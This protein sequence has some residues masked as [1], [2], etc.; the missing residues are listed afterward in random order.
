[1]GLSLGAVAVVLLGLVGTAASSLR[2]TTRRIEAGYTTTK[3]TYDTGT[4][5]TS[6]TASSSP[7]TTRRSGSTPTSG[8]PPKVT[9]LASNPLFGAVTTSMVTCALTRYQ[10]TIAGQQKLLTEGLGCLDAMWKPML[11]E[12]GLPF[13]SP[14]L[15][16]PSGKNWSSPCG[17]VSNG[18]AAAF[19]C[20]Q[21]STLYMPWSGLQSDEYGPQPGIYL[22]V[23]AHEYGH[24]VQNLSGIS[25]AYQTQ[26]YDTGSYDTPQALELSRR[27]ELQAQCFS[28]T[29]FA[30]AEGR[31][32]FDRIIVAQGEATE[33]RGDGQRA[34]HDHGTNA[35]AQSWWDLG[36]RKHTTQQCNTWSALS[37]D[38]A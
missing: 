11:S 22:A 9:Q 36:L 34:R 33:Q 19:Y 1:M 29:F 37:A 12:A 38:I 3:P 24:H 27:L 7:R 16:F 2:H 23:L 28:G 21:N 4:E 8:A 35:H 26:A 5:P 17:S 30:A 32:T 6:S 13:T 31:G 18:E 14:Q 25:D 20:A 10:H 15:A